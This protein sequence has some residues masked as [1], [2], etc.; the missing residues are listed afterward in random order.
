MKNPFKFG[1]LKPK[2]KGDDDSLLSY[3]GNGHNKHRGSGG[4]LKE[5]GGGATFSGRWET[6]PL[7]KGARQHNQSFPVGQD[8]NLQL[9][10]VLSTTGHHSTR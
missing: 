5:L 4:G 10:N 2:S 3:P 7:G 6:P 1:C 9:L 8:A